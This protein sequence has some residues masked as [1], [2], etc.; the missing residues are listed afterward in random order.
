MLIQ[1]FLELTP[2]TFAIFYHSA[3]ANFS[4]KKADDLSLHFFLGVEIWHALIFV[5][6]FFVI[7][8][9][10]IYFQNFF[11][12][13]FPWLMA[14]VLFAMSVVSFFWYFRHSKSHTDSYESTT[15]L[16]ISRKLSRCLITQARR[17]KSRTDAFLLGLAASSLELIFTLP[18]YIICILTLYLHPILPT[19]AAIIIY[20]L[21]AL[22]PLFTIHAYS[23]NH[24]LAEIQHLRVKNKSLHRLI[25]SLGYLAIAI[26][27]ILMELFV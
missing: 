11:T 16:F 20:I 27:T 9:L 7:T 2:G 8:I 26:L 19:S 14:G 10:T 22:I 6:T 17:T 12:Q 23:H 21:T 18:L 13:I 15:A 5:I 1:A 4:S 3:L 24:N 25:I